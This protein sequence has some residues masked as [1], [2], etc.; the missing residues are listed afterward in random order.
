[1]IV[2]NALAE[3]IAKLAISAGKPQE[4]AEPSPGEGTAY[5]PEPSQFRYSKA[6]PLMRKLIKV[7]LAETEPSQEKREYWTEGR[8]KARAARV[9]KN[10]HSRKN[11]E[12]VL[13]GAGKRR[14][15]IPKHVLTK[16]DLEKHLGFV[17]VTIAVP[18]SGQKQFGSW[19]HPYNNNHLHDHGSHWVMHEDDHASSTMLVHRR[20]LEIQKARERAAVAK[21]SG[22]GGGAKKPQ[23]GLL[24]IAKTTIQGLPHVIGEG[25]PGMFSY[26]KNRILGGG[27]MLD[28]VQNDLPRRY[29][30]RV[31]RMKASPTYQRAAA[32]SHEALEQ[33]RHLPHKAN[34]M[35]Q[36]ALRKQAMSY[37]EAVRAGHF[38]QMG[39]HRDAAGGMSRGHVADAPVG[40]GLYDALAYAAE[41]MA[42]GHRASTG[43]R[44]G[45]SSSNAYLQHQLKT[46]AAKNPKNLHTRGLATEAHARG[47]D[48]HGVRPIDPKLIRKPS[49]TL[50]QA[51]AGLAGSLSLGLIAERGFKSKT[52]LEKT[53]QFEKLR[54]LARAKGI[55]TGFN[56]TGDAFFDPGKRRISVDK[57][58]RPSVF[59]HELG[60]GM[61]SS[62]GARALDRMYAPSKLYGRWALPLASVYG[63]VAR[64]DTSLIK[65]PED[66]IKH[67]TKA[68]KF[69]GA[70]SLPYAPVLAEEARASIRAV[71]LA[72]RTG[73]TRSAIGT[74]A[75]LTPAFGTYAM[76]L[77]APA[78][79]AYTLQ[80]KKRKI[81]EQM[82][83][84]Q[85]K[86]Q[87]AAI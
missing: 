6:P 30:R 26:T 77:A 61:N 55:R 8:Q 78:V 24:E 46:R 53:P 58:H 56:T 59:M 48:T 21:S 13:T 27:S 75:A 72:H 28:K 33:I 7:A 14:I 18:E 38:K 3:E 82:A 76:G 2:R 47:Q 37:R 11:T 44:Q 23:T 12:G 51:L 19:R 41:S 34:A 67:L 9:F 10:L 73:G 22:K 40:G 32:G 20:K 68:Q 54:R 65:K 74:A 71:G 63:T 66:Q 15:A 57:M 85:A 64:G 69:L 25:V 87:P 31:R 45:A 35:R 49:S 79:G 29:H 16:T 39:S 5:P 60:H 4:L 86:E 17:P 1:M 52:P 50:P 81:R 36:D 70:A 83:K 42:P 62:R 84:Q 43:L 80:R